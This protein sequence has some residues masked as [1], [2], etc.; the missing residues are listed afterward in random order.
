MKALSC[1]GVVM[2][3]ASGGSAS[4]FAFVVDSTGDAAD[5]SIDGM[6]ATAQGACTLRAAIQEANATAGSDSISFS[7]GF[8]GDAS[9]S[10]IQ[11]GSTLPAVTAPLMVDGG[12]CP[13]GALEHRPCNRV[14]ASAS[15]SQRTSGSRAGFSAA[16]GSLRSPENDG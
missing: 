2:L 8:D 14:P 4:A 11:P 9:G 13:A 10:T 1:V 6:C 12:D 3:F 16:P 5:V 7:A 15:P